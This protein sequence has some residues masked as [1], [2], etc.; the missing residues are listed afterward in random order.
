MPVA[1][2]SA[3]NY[4]EISNIYYVELTK[5]FEKSLNHT[6]YKEKI[7]FVKFFH[8]E[9]HIFKAHFPLEDFS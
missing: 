3:V 6:R 2:Y 5:I 4:H 8:Q 1:F 9:Q 7:Q